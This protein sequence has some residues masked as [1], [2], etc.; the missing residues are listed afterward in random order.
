MNSHMLEALTVSGLVVPSVEILLRTI[1]RKGNSMGLSGNPTVTSFPFTFS[2]AINGARG[3][4]AET[5][6]IM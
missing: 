3:W 2:R 6:S 5:V 1:G 4:V